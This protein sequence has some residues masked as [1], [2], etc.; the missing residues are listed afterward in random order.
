MD[1]DAERIATAI[2]AE[3][4]AE[5]DAGVPH[6]AAVDSGAVFFGLRGE[7]ADGGEFAPEA[8]RAGAWGV[9]IG[10]AVT[11]SQFAAY[12]EGKSE[13]APRGWV[14]AVADPLA[15]LQRLA[16]EWRRELGARVVG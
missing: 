7:R 6:R 11:R 4:L 2:G 16:T 8:L 15:A 3:I 1:L 13:H 5:G 12:D 10:E 14:F 9:V